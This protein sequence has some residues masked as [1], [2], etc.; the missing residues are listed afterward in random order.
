[1]VTSGGLDM[2]SQ[3]F[4][5]L[6]A[7]RPTLADLAAFA[8]GYVHSDPTSSLVKQRTILERMVDAIY[9]EYRLP[10]P[11]YDG[12]VELLNAADFRKTVPDVVVAKLHALR[13]AGNK[14]A[15]AG[16]K[17][18]LTSNAATPTVALE[19]LRNLHEVARWFHAQIDRGA[20]SGIA[21]FVAPKLASGEASAD[22]DA[23]EKLRVAEAKMAEMVA[24]L[25]AETKKLLA[26]EQV[27]TQSAAELGKL[28]QDGQEIA[29]ALHFSE[30]KTHRELI[31]RALVDAGWDVGPKATSTAQVK[32]E[33][34]V[35]AM[36]TESGEGYADYVLYGDDGLP[37]AVI[38]AKKTAKDAN[39]GAEQARIYAVCLEKETGK[40]PVI[41]FTNG[42]EIHVWDDVE[43]GP[44]RSIHG[45]YSKDSLDY[46]HHQRAN[47]K[48]L[49]TV[50]IDKDIAGRPYQVEAVKRVCELFTQ[51]HRRALIVQ[52]TGT[53]K[54]RVAVSLCD[55]LMR[56]SWA[57]RVLF[58][59]DRRELRKQADRA[60]K[61]FLPN[62]P[63]V[64]VGASTYKDRNKRIYLATYQS[65]DECYDDFDVGFFDLIIADE[66]HRSIYK[67]FR[68]IFQ[69]FDALQVGL[70]AT[71]VKF[72]ERNTY[73][74]FGCKDQDPTSSYGFKEAIDA[75]PP[76]LVP[77]RVRECNTWA[78][79]E[80]FTFKGMDDK[81]R[82]QL[83]AQAAD[84]EDIAFDAEDMDK[85]V[86]N[87]DTTR[88]VWSTI[89][90]EGI[91]E[92]TKS[93]VGKTI[94]F[95]RSHEHAM[96]LRTVFS[97]VY[98]QYGS[99]FCRVIDTQE[100]RRDQLIDDFKE[101]EK[102]PI[103]AISVD[104]LDTGIDVPEV[105]N[106]VFAKPVKSY[107]KF[108]QM[109]GRGTRLRKNLFGPGEDKTEFVIFDHWGNFRYFDEER[110]EKQ[111]T[112]QKSLAQQLFEA[113][114]LAAE[115]ALEKMDEAAFQGLVTLILADIA[116]LKATN[117]IDVREKRKELELLSDRER[118]AG[119]SAATVN[120]LRVIA[121]PLM[122]WRDINEQ[123]AAYAFDLLVT[124]LEAELLKGGPTATRVLDLRGRVLDD[125]ERLMK[126][127][128]PVKAKAATITSVRTD[129]FWAAA[130]VSALEAMRTQLRG[131]MQYQQQIATGHVAPRVFDVD[132]KQLAIDDYIPRLE[133][134]ELI[135][136]RTRVEAAVRKLLE[137]NA[138]L[139]RVRA[140]KAVSDED[141]EEVARLVLQMND[142]AN[143][144]YLA[145]HDPST[146]Q[147]LLT[148]FRSLVGLDA[149][150]VDQAFT[151]FVH[152]HPHLTASQ[153]RFLQVLQHHIASNGG[154]EIERLYE[155]PFTNLH[156]QSVDGVFPDAGDVDALLAILGTFEPRKALPSDRPPASRAESR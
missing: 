39:S 130:S 90:N 108:W 52:A 97:E 125:V 116:D 75:R 145:G 72:I 124:R 118:V 73:A 100:A 62:E 79:T 36:P 60:F 110:E 57:K 84:A 106:L 142:K 10:Q 13:I 59:C 120:D 55:V 61:E 150:A 119:F 47:R 99:G 34:R 91:R 65:M 85:S 26:L 21:A 96:H 8:E 94:V 121:A 123:R 93:R 35:S 127:Q 7:K 147:S 67:K 132:D 154:I 95:A 153:L 88:F 38:E 136:Y 149:E 24:A 20:T 102:E 128:G 139:Q 156:A 41:F 48:P 2:K 151:S 112:E 50:P 9:Q 37:L 3:N 30:E 131:I 87:K 144:K 18:S 117:A 46:L 114:V 28:K 76:H 111:P 6:R 138:T 146:R 140:G 22:K 4:E 17:G 134:M 29:S 113:R 126:N 19:S 89:M 1:M 77:F 82:Q 129:E 23:L 155:A 104:M 45:F 70:T 148:V 5:L 141:L 16:K 83:E 68:S 63:R 135:A 103:I 25:E 49:A 43:G 40:R 74:L 81:Q 107:V 92:G 15:H 12:L 152:A 44:H 14:G 122:H 51:K 32:R 69:W 109:I 115:I 53:G 105:V 86:F 54:T 143:V 78:R 58:L 33:V 137:E 64:V 42:F 27:A 11:H 56:A 31:D 80:G 98:P 101:P 71:P 133:G 66:S